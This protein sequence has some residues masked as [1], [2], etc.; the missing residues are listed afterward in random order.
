MNDNNDKMMLKHEKGKEKEKEPHCCP[1]DDDEDEA[2]AESGID[3]IA[4]ML[5]EV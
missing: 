3:L 2:M 1:W 4:S 5:D